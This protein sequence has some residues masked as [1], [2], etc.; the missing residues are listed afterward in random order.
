[1]GRPVHI[2]P[3]PTGTSRR[4]FFA[5][6]GSAAM[7]LAAVPMPSLAGREGDDQDGDDDTNDSRMGRVRFEHG[8][9]SGDPLRQRVILW[10]RVTPTSPAGS[11]TVSWQVARDPK[12]SQVVSRGE[13]LMAPETLSVG[14]LTLEAQ[15]AADALAIAPLELADLLVDRSQ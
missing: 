11:Q 12:F 5:R 13:T 14:S 6:S 15:P 9:A 1:M 2:K 4:G 8:V 3:R 7:A 10:T